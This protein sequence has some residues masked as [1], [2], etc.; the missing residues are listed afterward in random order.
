[1]QAAQAYLDWLTFFPTDPLADDAM[2]K[3]A[4]AEMR[5]MGL[6]DRDVTHARKAE[7]RLKALLQ[8]YPQS[9]LRATVEARLREAQESLAM[10]SYK[11][12]DFYLESRYKGHKGGLKGAQSR[13]KEVIDKYKDFSLRDAA[14]FKLAYTYQQ[15][16]EPDEA[17][18][19]YQDLLRNF[20]NSDFA[21]KAKDQ[22]SIIG[23]PVPD[24]DPARKSFVGP[25]SPGFVGNLMKEVMGKADVTVD[26]DGILI[27]RDKKE[28]H[29]DLI[30]EA[31]KYNGQLPTNVMPNAP[32]QRGIA[33]PTPANP[34]PSPKP[35]N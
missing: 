22:L 2:L 14:L 28:G 10:H 6:S 11:I 26:T 17:A 3:V 25:A 1:V 24:P 18:R 33:S 30:D 27:S 21:D 19:Y 31:L 8:Q 7:Q 15:E 23:V 4:E 35:T 12:G 34:N 29:E 20:P 13:Y 9:N 32:V 5:Q 16:E